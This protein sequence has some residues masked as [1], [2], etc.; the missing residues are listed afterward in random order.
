MMQLRRYLALGL[1]R[2]SVRRANRLIK[3]NRHAAAVKLLMRAAIAGNAEAAYRLGRGY[4]QGSYFP[5][6]EAEATR[7]LELAAGGGVVAAQTRLAALNLRGLRHRS[8]A[9][10]TAL[11][12]LFE[13][14]AR[15]EPDYAAALGWA[16]RAA[17][18]GCGEAQALA[19]YILSFGPASM[20]D[21]GSGDELYARSAATGC[22]QGVLGH[23]LSKARSAA[24]FADWDRVRTL[25]Q[26]IED[27]PAA[28]YVLGLIHQDGKGTAR[29]LALALSYFRRAAEQGHRHAQTALGALLIDGAAGER[30]LIAGETWL[31]RGAS[32]GDHAA[33]HRLAELYIGSGPLP[34]NYTEAANWLR[35]AAQGGDGVAARRLGLL[36]LTGQELACDPEEALRWLLMAA[37]AGDQDART[38]VGNLLLAGVAHPAAAD[39]VRRQW[40]AAARQGDAAAAYNLGLC[41]SQCLG[42]EQDETAAAAWFRQSAERVPEAQYAYGRMLAEGNGV[43]ADAAAA[44]GWLARAAQA[45]LADAQVALAEMLVNGRGGPASPS[46]ARVL[47]E[48]A[49]TAGHVGAMFALGAMYGGG[50]GIAA[51]ERL[52]RHWIGA[53]A[54]R[55]HAGACAYLADSQPSLASA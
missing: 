55:G 29:D 34:P 30:D 5:P 3:R 4:L 23:A 42:T 17:E 12:A 45:G 13:P 1:S 37:E 46:Q 36:Y 7:W 18:G 49:A 48:Q 19:A 31:R 8:V 40:E 15:S 44:R 25:L 9:A 27:L 28:A 21:L 20:V 33:A 22:P 54:E 38:Q 26:P 41:C 50:H 47:F 32:A 24:S 39:Y 52:A 16:L 35:R 14:R 2:R 11:D 51:D 10:D 6:C 53:A 43:P